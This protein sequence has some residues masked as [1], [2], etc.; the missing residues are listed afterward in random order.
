MGQLAINGGGGG[1]VRGTIRIQAWS[2]G[3]SGQQRQ[4]LCAGSNYLRGSPGGLP[5]PASDA[6]IR[7]VGGSLTIKSLSKL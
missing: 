3:S 6:V 4:G 2:E 5:Y 7:K 1:G